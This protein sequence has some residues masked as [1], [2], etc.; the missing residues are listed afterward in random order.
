MS[1]SIESTAVDWIQRRSQIRLASATPRNS[2]RR[3]SG[4]S[5]ELSPRLI[6]PSTIAAMTSGTAVLAATPRNAAMNMTV[7]CQRQGP[8]YRRNHH[9]AA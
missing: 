8:A 5:S 1:R 3:N 9:N 2:T 7:I 6:G 4:I